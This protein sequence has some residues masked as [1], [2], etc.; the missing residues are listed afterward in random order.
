MA[1]ITIE[2]SMTILKEINL[3]R[4]LGWALYGSDVNDRFY[5]FSLRKLLDDDTFLKMEVLIPVKND[6]KIQPDLA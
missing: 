5:I 1:N 3:F 4:T 2:Q 6:P